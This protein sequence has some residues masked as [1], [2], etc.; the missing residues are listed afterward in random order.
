MNPI[1]EY[2]RFSTAPRAL[3]SAPEAAR[4]RFTER[5]NA[6]GGTLF[7][8][9]RSVVGLGLARDEGIAVTSWASVEA[10][11]AAPPVANSERTLLQA[12]VRPLTDA[13]PKYEGVYVFRWFDVAEAEWQDFCDLSNAAWLNMESVFDVNICGF[14]KSLD[15]HA[16]SSK[17]LLLT[18]Y[19]DLSVWEASRWWNKPVA[20]ADASM[21]RFKARNE[22]IDATIAYPALPIF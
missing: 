9:W 17:T 2:C 3:Q 14:W 5:A 8:C 22:M 7:G 4:K 15:T 6:S 16:P 13:A 21:N 1:Y 18:R 20:A 11:T 10:A 19:A 12:T